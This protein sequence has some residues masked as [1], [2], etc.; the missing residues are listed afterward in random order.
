MNDK[1]KLNLSI[2]KSTK[3]IATERAQAEKITVSKLFSILVN[4]QLFVS[5]IDMA[6]LNKT[7]I[8]LNLIEQHLYQIKKSLFEAAE[9]NRELNPEFDGLKI[10]IEDIHT[11]ISESIKIIDEFFYIYLFKFKRV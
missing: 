2:S 6:S 8:C 9:N 4:N 3:K 1:V 5:D 10:K 11:K 7:N